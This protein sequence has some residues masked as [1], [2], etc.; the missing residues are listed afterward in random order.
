M[1][2][3]RVVS[4]KRV[5]LIDDEADVREVVQACL[6]D[7]GGWDVLAVASP[8]EG[9]DKAVAIQPDAII[10]DISMPAMNG[11]A[12]LQRLRANSITQHIPVVFL[13]AKARW[14]TPQQLQAFDVAGA[15]AKPFNP[16]SLTD[17]IAKT[18]GW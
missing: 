4:T 1:R 12:F 2:T 14:F 7:V 17:E 16:L 15:I 8:Q 10:L 18:L 13:T 3:L 5:L 11:F 6:Q 9:L